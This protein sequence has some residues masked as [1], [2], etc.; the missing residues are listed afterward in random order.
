MNLEVEWSVCE[1]IELIVRLQ[2]WLS[3]QRVT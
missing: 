3:E 1:R 2:F